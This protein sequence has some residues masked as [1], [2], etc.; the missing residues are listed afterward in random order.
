[1]QLSI[2]FGLAAASRERPL[3]CDGATKPDLTD[4]YSVQ[5]PAQDFNV[6]FVW[7]WWF[8]AGF[9]PKLCMVRLCN[10]IWQVTLRSCA[11]GLSWKRQPLTSLCFVSLWCVIGV[12]A[13]TLRELGQPDRS[14]LSQ[15]AS[16]FGIW[17]CR[18]YGARWLG[19]DILRI[20]WGRC[21]ENTVAS[22][23]SHTLLPRT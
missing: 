19:P 9:S 18:P 14:V 12:T 17:V 4:S 8:T 7:K 15:E 5:S 20:R 2:K 11:M 3:S 16:L 10:L 21:A 22:S 6:V 23:E 13:T 1:V